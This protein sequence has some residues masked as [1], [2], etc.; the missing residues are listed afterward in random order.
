MWLGLVA[1][2]CLFVVVVFLFISCG[3]VCWFWIGGCCGVY[4]SGSV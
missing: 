3:L 4:A 2:V 1:V